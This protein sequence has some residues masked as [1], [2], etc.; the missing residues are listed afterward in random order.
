MLSTVRIAAIM[1]GIGVSVTTTL[2][3]YTSLVQNPKI[4][5]RLSSKKD[6]DSDRISGASNAHCSLDK[7]SPCDDS[8]LACSDVVGTSIFAVFASQMANDQANISLRMELCSHDHCNRSS[9]VRFSLIT[10][11][12]NLRPK[13]LMMVTVMDLVDGLEDGR[14]HVPCD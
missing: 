8:A 14:T 11:D 6:R 4:S 12:E 2:V 7:S 9:L 10:K 13:P 3:S 1:L 5:V